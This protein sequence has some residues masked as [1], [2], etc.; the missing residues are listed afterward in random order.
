MVVPDDSA[1]HME[2]ISPI[3][4][5]N[6]AAVIRV[7]VRYCAACHRKA[8]ASALHRNSAAAKR[9]SVVPE[10]FVA[11]YCAPLIIFLP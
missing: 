8:T 4:K 7:I 3:Y 2:F 6:T 5:R 1:R 10:R 11:A 9:S